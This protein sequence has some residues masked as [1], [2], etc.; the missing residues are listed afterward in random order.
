MIKKALLEVT[1]LQQLDKLHKA[2]TAL[3]HVAVEVDLE[4]A[5]HELVRDCFEVL[6]DR[7]N[8]LRKKHIKPLVD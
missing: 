8:E 4:T 3:Y 5:D 6:E 7:Y 2:I 1:K